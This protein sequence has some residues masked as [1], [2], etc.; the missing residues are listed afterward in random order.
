MDGE[1]LTG[2]KWISLPSVGPPDIENNTLRFEINEPQFQGCE[3]KTILQITCYYVNGT[4]HKLAPFNGIQ[5]D[6]ESLQGE[7]NEKCYAVAYMSDSDI[8]PDYGERTKSDFF[9]PFR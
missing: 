4:D 3:Q 5:I 9:T 6:L 8:K 7:D 2:Y 1:T